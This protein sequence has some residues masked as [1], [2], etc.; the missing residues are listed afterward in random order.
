MMH[1]RSVESDCGGDQIPVVKFPVG[2]AMACQLNVYANAMG[3]TEDAIEARRR[4]LFRYA[5]TFGMSREE[6]LDLSEIILRRDIPSWDDL[7]STEVSRLLDAF[8]G[9][10]LIMHLL[11]TRV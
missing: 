3:D 4:K 10:A 5:K 8:E 2:G 6:R 1:P 11:E 7:N 9:A